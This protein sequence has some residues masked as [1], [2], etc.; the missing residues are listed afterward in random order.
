MK[1]LRGAIDSGWF[2]DDKVAERLATFQ[3]KGAAGLAR[4]QAAVDAGA[5]PTIV[6]A[7]RAHE[8]DARV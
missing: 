4:Q 1:L 7:M 6:A 2:D 5:L 8:A 3:D